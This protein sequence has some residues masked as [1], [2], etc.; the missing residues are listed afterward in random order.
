MAYF[1]PPGEGLRFFNAT[2]WADVFQEFRD[3]PDRDWARD[4]KA[5]PAYSRYAAE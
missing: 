2:D 1:G 4:F 5:S 3:R